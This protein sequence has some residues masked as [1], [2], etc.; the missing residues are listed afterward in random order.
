VPVYTGWPREAVASML[1][2][3]FMPFNLT[4]GGLNAAFVMLLYKPIKTALLASRMVVQSPEE[5]KN[6][7]FNPGVILISLFVILT[8]VLWVLVIHGII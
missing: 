7:L 1:L 3:T 2:P 5:K 8:C 6:M 4:K